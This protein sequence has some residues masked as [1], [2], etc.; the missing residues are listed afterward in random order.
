MKQTNKKKKRKN[1][2]IIYKCEDPNIQITKY[3]NKHL[4][5]VLYTVNILRMHMNS[6]SHD[7]YINFNF[8]YCNRI[9]NEQHGSHSHSLQ[10]IK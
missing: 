3:P 9:L 5:G 2:V 1:N 6:F 4:I 10:P 8:N 7:W